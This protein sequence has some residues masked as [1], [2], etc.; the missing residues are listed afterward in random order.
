MG[1][2][3]LTRALRELAGN[4]RHNALRAALVELQPAP[5]WCQPQVL[6]APDLP[7]KFGG[8]FVRCWVLEHWEP[9][10]TG[11]IRTLRAR[12]GDGLRLFHR[13]ELDHERLG[14]CRADIF[15]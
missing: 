2:V 5:D 13:L 12:L 4:E 15:R 14:G 10:L 9:R 6:G 8:G 7:V 3:K 1:R 11:T